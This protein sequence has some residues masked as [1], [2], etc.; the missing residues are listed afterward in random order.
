MLVTRVVATPETHLT[1]RD[2]TSIL[3]ADWGP[4]LHSRTESRPDSRMSSNRLR[5]NASKTEFIW[6]GS[7]RGSAPSYLARFFTPVSAIAGRSQ[8]RSAAAGV[9]LVP[10]SHT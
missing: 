7:T 2:Y 9:L 6:L 1:R 8:L 10:S 3:L 5:L 4:H